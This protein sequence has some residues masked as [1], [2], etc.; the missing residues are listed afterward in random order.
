MDGSAITLFQHLNF[1]T[2]TWFAQMNQET[3]DH[4]NSFF[5]YLPRVSIALAFLPLLAKEI[6]PV[7]IRTTFALGMS[8]WLSAV[9]PVSD[10]TIY[11]N[12]LGFI[13]RE[14]LIGFALSVTFGTIFWA[15]E[16]AGHI[17]D[18][19]T[20]LTAAQQADPANANQSSPLSSMLAR[21][22]KTYIIAIGGLLLF[23]KALCESFYLWKPTGTAASLGSQY[24]SWLSGSASTIFSLAVLVAAPICLVLFFVD[25]CI[26]FANKTASSLEVSSI[27]A[28]LKG[29]LALFLLISAVPLLAERL[30]SISGDWQ[31]LLH[32]LK[33]AIQTS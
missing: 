27:T 18:F 23:L 25:V 17:V 33:N 10:V 9:A 28:G 32:S 24:V 5:V 22:G 1:R 4:A 26:G 3:L 30:L 31:L 19:Y 11:E 14:A 6:V 15:L 7:S 13:L 20:G 16:S 29:L 21:F 12:V 2:D 8:F